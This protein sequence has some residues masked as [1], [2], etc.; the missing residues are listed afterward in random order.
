M[1]PFRYTNIE[2]ECTNSQCCSFLTERN[3]RYRFHYLDKKVRQFQNDSEMTL[4]K[5]FTFVRFRK[6]SYSDISRK[7]FKINSFDIWVNSNRK[8]PLLLNAVNQMFPHD[9]ICKLQQIYIWD[10][11]FS[12][13]SH[14]HFLFGCIL[15]K[16]S[17]LSALC[18]L[19]VLSKK[20][21]TKWDLLQ[22][23]ILKTH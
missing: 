7:H 14:H 17:A 10:H 16:S 20:C 1:S 13:H 15:N 19:K 2:N 9:H 5:F 4:T 8:N 23:S 22:P 3:L 12:H 6:E 18:S 21:Q 11:F